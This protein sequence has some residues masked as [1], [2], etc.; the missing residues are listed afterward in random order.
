MGSV[1]LGSLEVLQLTQR[2]I[3]VEEETNEFPVSCIDNKQEGVLALAGGVNESARTFHLGGKSRYLFSEKNLVE[4]VRRKHFFG[5][6][7]VIKY[8]PCPFLRARL[9]PAKRVI[10]YRD[11]WNFRSFT[12]FILHF[13]QRRTKQK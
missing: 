2:M 8:C 10:V 12:I 1:R 9:N 4:R 5:I 6:N 13:V 7:V 3:G 11:K